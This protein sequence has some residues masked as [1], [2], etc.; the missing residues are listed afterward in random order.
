MEVLTIN[1]QI[2]FA[3]VAKKDCEI[4]AVL[5]FEKIKKLK[6]KNIIKNIRA[7]FAEFK[8]F[9][10]GQPNYSRHF[11]ECFG[12]NKRFGFSPIFIF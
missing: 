11:C 7:A 6:I 9:G 4:Y 5:F 8:F 1:D 12:N 10:G 2:S 3:L